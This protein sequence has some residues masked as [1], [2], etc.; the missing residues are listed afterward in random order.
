M[1]N[2]DDLACY[3]RVVEAV[4][5]DRGR[6]PRRYHYFWEFWSVLQN[7]NKNRLIILQAPT[8]AGKTETVLSPFIWDLVGGE[9]RWH[10]LI[11]VLPT[12]SLVYNMFYRI[13]KALSSCM[14]SFDV[15]RVVVDYDYGGFTPFKAFLEGD[16]TVTT[17]DTLIY[18][19][20]GFRSYGHH[21]LLSIGKVA[22]SLVVLDEVQLLQD[23]EWYS[24][25]LLPHHIANLVK[26]GA[27]VILMTATLPK[28]LAWDVNEALPKPY[29]GMSCSCLSVRADPDRDSVARGRLSVSMRD[30]RLIDHVLEIAGSYEKP[31][32]LVFNTVERA[33]EAYRILKENGYGDVVL[34][35]SRLIS[36]ERRRREESFEMKPENPNLIV[37]ATQVVEAGIDYD[38]RTVATEISPIDSL[39]QRLGRCA[40]RR[41][42]EALVFM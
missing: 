21:L 32:L 10:S 39:I 34:L 27:T 33:V 14:R 4:V 38:F 30:D 18:T 23:A 2:P 42:G 15:P 28:I 36:D 25:T 37:I 7:Y 19:F 11:Y 8:G 12:R 13:C 40:R 5:R 3:W 17:Y 6:E 26:F 16:I 31:M 22:G 41:D 35:H 24:L 29:S 20:Y 1:P 9:R